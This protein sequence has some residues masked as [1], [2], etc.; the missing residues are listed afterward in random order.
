MRLAPMALLL[1][2]CGNPPRIG[3]LRAAI[4]GGVEPEGADATVAVGYVAEASGFVGSCSGTLVAPS[5][6]LT[7]KHC[8]PR[9]FECRVGGGF[10]VGLGPLG[11][12]RQILVREA[13]C[14]PNACG[15][16]CPPGWNFVGEDLALAILEEP[17]LDIDA[18]PVAWEGDGLEVGDVVRLIGYGL[19][20]TLESGRRLATDDEVAT[21]WDDE[22]VM[23]GNGV[24]PG[25]SGG[26]VVDDAGRVVGV[27][28]RTSD[29][30]CNLPPPDRLTFATRVTA[31]LE[32]V[33]GAIGAADP[34]GDPRDADAGDADGGDDPDAGSEGADSGPAVRRPGKGCAAAGPA[35]GLAAG[36]LLALARLARGGSVRVSWRAHGQPREDDP[37]DAR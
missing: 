17:I 12:D 25:D 34:Q 37:G 35:P 8:I 7:A 24:C 33:Q 30:R 36:M 26:S 19:T 4:L 32:L 9:P 2:A 23:R 3:S 10:A 18:L 21:L 11:L 28:A 22:I 13:V 14:A 31:W 15:D 29:D 16:D 1:A 5:V 27:I 20:E 6:V